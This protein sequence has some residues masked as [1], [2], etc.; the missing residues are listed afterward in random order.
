MLTHY[1][2]QHARV[3]H[4]W[5][6]T[7]ALEL[8]PPSSSF[9][10]FLRSSL[11]HS[12]IAPPALP[13]CRRESVSMALAW[14]YTGG[15]WPDCRKY[16]FSGGIFN[17]SELGTPMATAIQPKVEPLDRG[18]IV[19]LLCVSPNRDCRVARLPLSPITITP[20]ADTTSAGPGDVHVSRVDISR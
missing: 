8:P 20:K 10:A 16:F 13:P 4:P 14:T 12:S 19:A 6:C 18:Q 15:V 11:L 9:A 1:I 17:M 3:H 7:Y 2:S 5:V